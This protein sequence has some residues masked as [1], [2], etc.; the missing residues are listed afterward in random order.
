MS[1]IVRELKCGMW[2]NAIYIPWVSGQYGVSITNDSSR[3]TAIFTND[4]RGILSSASIELGGKEITSGIT[5]PM[6]QLDNQQATAFNISEIAY[7]QLSG[8]DS[9]GVSSLGG[10][11]GTFEPNGTW[12]GD[13]GKTIGMAFLALIA[14]L[15]T[16]LMVLISS[17]SLIVY[18]LTMIF[19]IILSPLFFLVGAA[20]GWGR[21]IAMRWLELIVGLL[22]KRVVVALVLAVFI[23]FYTIVMNIQGIDYLFQLILIIAVTIVGLS[24]RTKIIRI[25]TDVID[26]GGNKKLLSGEGG[27]GTGQ[28]I[29]AGITGAAVGGIAAASGVGG[30]ITSA[31]V[32]SIVGPGSV[33][34]G[35]PDD[36]T[37]APLPASNTATPT[38][39]S[40]SPA[41]PTL[42]APEQGRDPMETEM[43]DLG[44]PFTPATPVRPT[45]P[46]A[47]TPAVGAGTRVKPPQIDADEITRNLRKKAVKQGIMKGAEQGFLGGKLNA[48]TLYAASQLG[49]GIGDGKYDN[50][51]AKLEAQGRTFRDQQMLELF[52]DQLNAAQNTEAAVDRRHQEMLEATAK[53]GSGGLS[54]EIERIIDDT[55]RTANRIDR[56]TNDIKAAINKGAFPPKPEDAPK[57]A[58]GSDGKSG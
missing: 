23:K 15:G 42:S 54:P 31:M 13:P 30:G 52:G 3:A 37:S 48:Q 35:T 1:S 33:P 36:G 14:S 11:A 24:Q 39:P 45:E 5:W 17:F 20:P 16:S 7:A 58:P 57:R 44:I 22:M 25:F 9:N 19:L 46:T 41:R 56:K 18:Q 53:G 40:S 43:I 34:G 2:Y 21:R 38:L 6:Y 55:R 10:D 8:V 12:A 26:F 32:G 49:Y 28:R 29:L 27:N 51:V 4:P 50:E 47:G